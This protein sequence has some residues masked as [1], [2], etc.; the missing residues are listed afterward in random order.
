[1]SWGTSIKDFKTYLRLEKSLAAN[2]ID[3]YT[4]DLEKLLQFLDM[5]KIEVTPQKLSLAHLQAFVK[6]VTDLG[7]TPSSQARMISGIR[8]FYKYL[9][10]EDEISVSPAELIELPALSRKLPDVLSL[11]EVNKIIEVIDLT[12]TTGHRNKAIVETMFSCGLRVSEAVQLKISNLS[13]KSAF[14]K[15]TGKGNKERLVPIGNPAIRAIEQYIEGYRSQ[16]KVQAQSSDIVFLNINGKQMSRQMVFIFLKQLAAQAG[17]KK[18]ISPHTLRHSFA[19]ALVEG[20]A[21][22][23]AVQQMLGHESIT[24]TE[25]YAHIDREFLR[26][27]LIQFHPRA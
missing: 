13:F 2:S 18:N 14:I 5:F 8:S 17:I 27:T 22:L 7:M 10:I 1:M 4:H 11:E 12:K 9:L 19:T 21:D 25:I 23:R 3:A 24:T 6:W 16:G 20:G 15:V 26:D